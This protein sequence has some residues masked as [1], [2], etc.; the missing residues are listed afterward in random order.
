MCQRNDRGDG[1]PIARTTQRR[2]QSVSSRRA[3][4]T[5]TNMRDDLRGCDLNTG[6]PLP[7]VVISRDT[8]RMHHHSEELRNVRL[9]KTTRAVPRVLPVLIAIIRMRCQLG[10]DL[11]NVQ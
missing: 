6:E 2:Q 7:S 5:W 3:L 10:H 11:D 9:A 8:W 1:Y 4:P